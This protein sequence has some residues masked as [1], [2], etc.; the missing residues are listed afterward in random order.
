MTDL[1][2]WPCGNQTLNLTE[3][4]VMGVLNVTP[5]SFSDGGHFIG[6]DQALRHATEMVD[7][8]AAIIDIGGESTRPGATPVSVQEELDRVI[9][10]IEALAGRVD[11]VLSVDT[12]TPEVMR[13][14]ARA[15]VHLLNDVRALSRDGALEAAAGLGLPVCLMHMQGQ[16]GT[17]QL[18]PQ[19]GD[20]VGEVLRYL[21]DR[22]AACEA[23][24]MKRQQL[25]VDPGFGF[26]KT[27]GHNLR[28]LNELDRLQS[29]GCPILVGMSRKSMIGDV[30]GKPVDQRLY[31]SLAV[32]VAAAM[33]GAAI[34]RVHDVAETVDAITM[35]NAMRQSGQDPAVN[36]EPKA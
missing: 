3:T 15:G 22:I 21:G 31:G 24:G 32:A 10:V 18:N 16:P 29:L 7:Q 25:L 28:L 4:Q 5:D 34:V 33:K 30:L 8:G 20:V 12:S 23:A 14:A 11:A 19:Y 35:I 17:M 27:V 1:S 9:P 13:E 26:G 2:K 36:G 6:H